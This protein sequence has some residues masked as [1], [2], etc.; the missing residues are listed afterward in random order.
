MQQDQGIRLL[1]QTKLIVIARGVAEQELLKTAEA[2][3]KG[4]VRV[5]EV[6]LNTEGATQL[7][8]TLQKEF[9]DE[10]WVGAGTVL[11]TEDADAAAEAGAQFLV[12]PHTDETLI[13]HAVSKQL[14]IYPG[15]LTPS[16]IVRAWNAGASAIKLFPSASLGF[17]YV[18]ELMGPFDRIPFIPVGGIHAENAKQFM[19]IGCYALGVG[20]YLIQRDAMAS[21]EYNRIAEK[22]RGLIQAINR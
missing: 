6:T 2:L 3:L 12:T 7:I 13:R 5:L 18:K 17:S 10:M 22:A 8:R 1:E 11:S 16:E 4:G 14:P 9:G 21:G 15:A 20:S 19:D